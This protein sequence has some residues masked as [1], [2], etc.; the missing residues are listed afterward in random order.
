MVWGDL[1]KCDYKIF[2]LPSNQS[3]QM[4]SRISYN[5]RKATRED[6]TA[7]YRLIKVFNMYS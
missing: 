4:A 3:P 5:V 1:I 7:V 2:K 6:V